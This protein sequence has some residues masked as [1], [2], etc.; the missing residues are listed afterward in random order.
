MIPF[1]LVATA[2]AVILAI[3]ARFEALARFEPLR[4]LALGYMLLI[5][6]G[7]GFLGQDL[8]RARIWRWLVLFVPLSFGMYFA[9]R[10]LFPATAHI[11]WPS[12][13]PRNLWAQAFDWIRENTPTDAFFALNP[14]HMALAGEDE[15]GFR[16]RAQ[17]S[18]LADAVKDK[19]AASAFPPLATDW[20]EQVEDQKNWKDFGKEDYQRLRKKYGINWVVLDQPASVGFDCPYQNAAVKVCR[21]D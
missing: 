7:G 20:M 4:C 19:G 5:V 8:L 2:A 17:R 1:I 16:A 9:Q 3:P 13:P 6:I 21:L 18:M 14:N 15:N 10:Q 12:A 11:E